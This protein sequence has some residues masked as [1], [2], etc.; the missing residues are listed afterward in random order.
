[1]VIR[2]FRAADR[3]ELIL[4]NR[5]LFV[6]DVSEV[7]V[8]LEGALALHAVDLHVLAVT[9]ACFADHVEVHL[10]GLLTLIVGD[11]LAIDFGQLR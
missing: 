7:F 1:M 10:A 9:V 2:L 11:L 3:V 6:R 8:A 4:A 5:L